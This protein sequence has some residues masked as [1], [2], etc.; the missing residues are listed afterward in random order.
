MILLRRQ[1]LAPLRF[2]L[3]NLFAHSSP[4][5]NI[6]TSSGIR[7]KSLAF[8]RAQRTESHERK[9]R[10]GAIIQENV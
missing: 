1:N 6:L 7:K 8:R 10:L 5:R 2:T 9:A 4:R 3:P